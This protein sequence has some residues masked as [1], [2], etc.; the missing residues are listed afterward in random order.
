MCKK[1]WHT[2]W[3]YL[4]TCSKAWSDNTQNKAAKNNKLIKLKLHSTP[5]YTVPYQ[6]RQESKN[7]AFREDGWQEQERPPTQ[8]ETDD[9]AE[10]C[11]ENLQELIHLALDRSNWQ[12]MVKQVSD[13]NGH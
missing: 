2:V 5:T 13:L 3:C 9:I 10:W 12:K 1:L 4:T 6:T 11:G 8:T 7:T